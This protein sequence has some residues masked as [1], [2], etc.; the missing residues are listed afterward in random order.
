MSYSS[1]C[2]NCLCLHFYGNENI[3]YP[4][5]C[6]CPLAFN[7]V[8][9]YVGECYGYLPLDNLEYLEWKVE[10]GDLNERKRHDNELKET[11]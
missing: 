1:R 3:Y 6:Y 7:T 5:K 8:L 2:R 10:F 11:V 4:T 9:E